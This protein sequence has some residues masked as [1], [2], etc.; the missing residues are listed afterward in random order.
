MIN[1]DDFAKIELKIARVVE[2]VRV[3][4]S[5]KL[6]KLQLDLGDPSTGSTSSPQASSGLGRRQI[7]AG[8]GKKYA[9]EDLVG[10]EIVIVANLE[11]R[12]LMGEESN[13]ML[14]ATND[15]NGIVLLVP[16]REV[17]PGSGVK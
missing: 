16:E 9:P 4:G 10:K 11:P 13:G 2:A 17:Q 3:E 6:I 14:L 7:V 12:K 15:E 5:E 1:Y 8:I